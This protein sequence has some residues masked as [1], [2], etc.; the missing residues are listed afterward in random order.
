MRFL[1]IGIA[2]S[3]DSV[4]ERDGRVKPGHDG[5]GVPRGD[6]AALDIRAAMPWLILPAR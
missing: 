1:L 3:A 2:S 5:D 6:A 4:R